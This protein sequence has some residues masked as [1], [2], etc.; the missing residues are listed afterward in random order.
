MFTTPHNSTR[1]AKELETTRRPNRKNIHECK[2]QKRVSTHR[3]DTSHT[4]YYSFYKRVQANDT[5]LA[6]RGMNEKH[7]NGRAHPGMIQAILCI[8]RSINVCRQMILFWRNAERMYSTKTGAH[9]QACHTMYYS[10]YKRV[11]INDTFMATRHNSTRVA[12]ELQT[13]R[14][15]RKTTHEYNVKHKSRRANPGMIQAMLS[16][17]RSLNVCRQM[18]LFGETRTG[19]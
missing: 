19:R 3:H 12:K 9:T 1:V 6:K 18:V 10:F 17:F 5:F 4:M 8:T 15:N 2:A 13:P 14:S 16:I 7:K 11:Q